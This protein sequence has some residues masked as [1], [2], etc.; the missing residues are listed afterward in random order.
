MTTSSRR[1]PKC[2]SKRIR[3]GNRSAIARRPHT[4]IPGNPHEFIHTNAPPLF[5]AEHR[6]GRLPRR[7]FGEVPAVHTSVCAGIVVPS[8]NRTPRSV[9][10][11]T[12]VF[13]LGEFFLCVGTLLFPQLRQQQRPRFDQHHPQMC[14][15]QVRIEFQCVPQKIIDSGD[16]LD[17]GKSA[18]CLLFAKTPARRE[19]NNIV[20]A[21]SP[22]VRKNSIWLPSDRDVGTYLF[23]FAAL[24]NPAENTSQPD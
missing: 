21:I 15:S 19:I 17:S 4:G 24:E 2:A 12:P 7:G 16:G 11:S 1:S 23:G 18:A 9:I 3:S 6:G 20:A 10:P 5:P 13:A 14:F 8:L 22:V